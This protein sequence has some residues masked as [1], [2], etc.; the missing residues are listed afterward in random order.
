VA[1]KNGFY[2]RSRRQGNKVVSEYVGGGYVGLLMEQ[3][4]QDERY[5][6]EIKRNAW[7]T[8]QAEQAAID[9]QIDAV[10]AAVAALVDAQLLSNGYHKHKREWR[11][12]RG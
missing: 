3:L 12:K 9:A 10:G 7:Q 4:D 8:A 1:W 5:K 2:Y 6:A 11:R